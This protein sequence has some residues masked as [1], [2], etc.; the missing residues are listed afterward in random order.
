MHIWLTV[1]NNG[2]RVTYFPHYSLSYIDVENTAF[3]IKTEDAHVIHA[4]ER[5]H[6]SRRVY[7]Y[8]PAGHA[9]FWEQV[10]DTHTVWNH[11][12]RYGVYESGF[13]SMR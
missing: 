5:D 3:S 2:D 10:T 7:R 11:I 8:D 12:D 4:V 6:R 9:A 1:R 13:Q